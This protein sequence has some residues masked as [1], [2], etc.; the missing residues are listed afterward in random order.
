LV[1]THYPNPETSGTSF[2]VF[3]LAAGINEGILD[4][5]KYEPVVR[6]GWLGL[7]NCVL[8]DGTL[9]YV[10]PIGGDPRPASPTSTHEY[11]V[12]AFLL[13][14][15]EVSEMGPPAPGSD[16]PPAPLPPYV[17]PTTKPAS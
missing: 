4:R 2:F 3:A 16:A 12:G 10:Q 17:A 6:R 8:A 14:A 1:A 11:A 7:N 15:K 13:A 5:A 9:G